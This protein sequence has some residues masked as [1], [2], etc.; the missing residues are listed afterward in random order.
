MASAS[1]YTALIPSENASAPK[2]SAMVGAVAGCFADLINAIESVEA[3]F[4]L[5]TAVGAQLDAVGVRVGISRQLSAQITGLY[6][7][8]DTAGLGFDAGVWQGPYDPTTGLVKMDDTSYRT[9]LRA[10]I[11]ANQWDGTLYSLRSILTQALSSY[12]TRVMVKDNQ[13]MSMTITLV[14]TLPP[15]I[16]LALIKGGYLSIRPVGVSQAYLKS[17]ISGTPAFAF[18]MNNT[19]GAGFDSGAWAVTL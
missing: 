9:V 14:G 17:S 3:S 19:Y 11:S 15:P 13:D 18:D 12:G 2:F 6:F 8:L 1:D 10:K 5:D 7:A 4:D 16:I